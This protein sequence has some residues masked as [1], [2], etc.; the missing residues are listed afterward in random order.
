MYYASDVHNT[1]VD[2][3]AGS[4]NQREICAEDKKFRDDTEMLYA[5]TL[6]Y[7]IGCQWPNWVAGTD[8]KR[9]DEALEY[10]K[11]NSADTKR[12]RSKFLSRGKK[13]WQLQW[14][15]VCGVACELWFSSWMFWALEQNLSWSPLP[16]VLYLLSVPELSLIDHPFSHLPLI[17]Q[18]SSL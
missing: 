17:S 4:W 14:R 11:V 3:Q 5:G 13:G 15:L 8:K 9:V 12:A 16:G 18:A 2:V 1:W 10:C 7:T 6:S